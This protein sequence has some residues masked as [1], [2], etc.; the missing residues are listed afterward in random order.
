M[1]TATTSYA[2][3][4]DTRSIVRSRVDT[5]GEHLRLIERHEKRGLGDAYVHAFGIA[6]DDGYDAVV[7]IDEKNV[8]CEP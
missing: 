3:T 7:E 5:D 8:H 4:D 1:I 6:L 2:S